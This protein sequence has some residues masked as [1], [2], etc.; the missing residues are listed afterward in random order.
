MD[1][2]AKKEKE[3]WVFAVLLIEGCN[4]IFIFTSIASKILK[5]NKPNEC[6]E[7]TAQTYWANCENE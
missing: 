3:N 4:C 6:N 2:V 5:P 1:L 7:K